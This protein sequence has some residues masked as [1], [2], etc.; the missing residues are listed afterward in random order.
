MCHIM[1]LVK[2]TKKMKGENKTGPGRMKE[3]MA[4]TDK[5]KK[6]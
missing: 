2:H 6:D 1:K 3:R 5:E 4:A